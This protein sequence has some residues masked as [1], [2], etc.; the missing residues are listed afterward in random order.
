[1]K[2]IT[3]ATRDAII[4]RELQIV[5]AKEPVE[6]RPALVAPSSLASRAVRLETRRYRAGRLNRLLIE[7]GLF[8]ALAIETL[9]PDRHKVAISFAALRFGKP[10]QRF[11][12][13]GDHAII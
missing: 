9:R 11:E 6:C 13:R 3:A 5:V 10:V 4:K 12:P 1:M 8:T 2:A 7:A